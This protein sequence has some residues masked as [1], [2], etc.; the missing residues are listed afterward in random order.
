M[1]AG[2]ALTSGATLRAALRFRFRCLL[3]C[4]AAQRAVPR[5]LNS[6]DSLLL[7]ILLKCARVRF[8]CVR[9]N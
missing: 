5:L 6:T 8:V 1:C 2:L 3:A 7:L 4:L 9:V